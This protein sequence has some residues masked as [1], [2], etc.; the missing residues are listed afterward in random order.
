MRTRCVEP[1]SLNRDVC[2][3][4]TAN[5]TPAPLLHELQSN[6]TTSLLVLRFLS[7]KSPAA[8]AMEN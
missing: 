6:T 8:E 3:P 1:S 7:A 4:K 2:V 5:R